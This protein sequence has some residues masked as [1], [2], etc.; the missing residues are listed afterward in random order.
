L[1]QS[2]VGRTSDAPLLSPMPRNVTAVQSL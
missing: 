1:L 2:T